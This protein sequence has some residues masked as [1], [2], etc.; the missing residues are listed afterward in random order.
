MQRS[1]NRQTAPAF[2]GEAQQRLQVP[3]HACDAH[4]DAMKYPIEMT[5]IRP[6]HYRPAGTP[7][8]SWKAIDDARPLLHG[9]NSLLADH[10]RK[11]MTEASGVAAI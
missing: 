1:T 2:L 7:I 11:I 8:S 6:M 10:V 4:L 5:E 9:E 3:L